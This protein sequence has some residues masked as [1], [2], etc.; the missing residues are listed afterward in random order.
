M[1]TEKATIAIVV[2]IVFATLM[3]S[4]LGTLVATQT[5]SNSGTVVTAIGVSVYTNSTCKATLSTITWG[6][7]NVGNV[8]TRTM[9]VKNTGNDAVTL[10]M[11]TSGWSPSYATSY[12]TFS[13]NEQSTQLAA[14]AGVTATLTLTGPSSVGNFTSFSFN[15]IIK[16]IGS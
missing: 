3:V 9:Y 8:T 4:A 5:I 7:L 13:W 2:A 6:S 14:G 15:I 1:A 12:F 11:T 16:G 10:N